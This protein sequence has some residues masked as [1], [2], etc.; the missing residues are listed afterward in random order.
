MKKAFSRLFWRI[1]LPFALALV[2]AIFQMMEMEG[3][4]GGGGHSTILDRRI[5]LCIDIIF[6][7]VLFG[8]ALRNNSLLGQGSGGF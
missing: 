5:L 8:I 2:I 3:R 7:C 6:F 4:G 1:I